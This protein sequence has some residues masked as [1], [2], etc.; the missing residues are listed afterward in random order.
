ML[1]ASHLPMSATV[2]VE[3]ESKQI[4][5]AVCRYILTHDLLTLSPDHSYRLEHVDS[6]QED[7]T[8]L[9]LTLGYGI[10]S[11]SHKNED[12]IFKRCSK[13]DPVA[14]RNC[15]R[16][17]AIHEVMSII[18][19]TADAIHKLCDDAV[20]EQDADIV[21]FFQTFTWNAENEFWQR[22]SF[23]PTRSFES[24]VLDSKVFSELKGDLDDFNAISTQSWYHK[25]GIP[26]R[27]G[28]LFH[29][30]PGTG[31]TSLISAIATYL[32]RRV[33]KIS[34]VAPRLND[35]SLHCAVN[36]AQNPAI[37]VM[38]DIDSLFSK[39][40][41]KKEESAVTFSGLLNAID[42]VGDCSKGIVFIFTTN[43]P[44][45]LDPALVRKGRI[46]RRFHLGRCNK[47]MCERMFLR[48]YPDCNS[49]AKQFA[50]NVKNV[51]KQMPPPVDLQHHFILHRLQSA[52]DATIFVP[53]EQFEFDKAPSAMWS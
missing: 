43:H 50:D 7:G 53:D 27:R 2:T 17:T 23:A 26:F 32:Q 42:G 46:D 15:D 5:Q 28:Y 31:K 36:N 1:K 6:R 10:F 51:C 21:D 11:F 41:E 35:D 47:N 38:E 39:H 52:A 14:G 16:E 13:G 19:P 4:V 3:L 44:E 37:I 20:K 22:V 12:F 18:G 33:H 40:R 49:E 45:Q 29:G 8:K 24:I 30:P 48:F 9:A 25:H 34:L